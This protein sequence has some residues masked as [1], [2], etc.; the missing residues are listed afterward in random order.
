MTGP[1]FLPCKRPSS[2]DPS[3]KCKWNKQQMFWR[4]HDHVI[5][6]QSR[7]PFMI[8]AHEHHLFVRRP[9]K[10]FDL[11]VIGSSCVPKGVF[12]ALKYSSPVNSWCQD[13]DCVDFQRT[14]LLNLNDAFAQKNR[15]IYFCLFS[16]DEIASLIYS[17]INVSGTLSNRCI[18]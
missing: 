12:A 14:L 7:C 15:I 8:P 11:P 3:Y 9:A 10:V 6:I 4:M 16:G 5:E 1:I 18:S 17:V 13:G 2:L